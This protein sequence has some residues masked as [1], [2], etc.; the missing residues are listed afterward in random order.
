MGFL[1]NRIYKILGFVSLSIIATFVLVYFFNPG[2]LNLSHFGFLK[3]DNAITL[4]LDLSKIDKSKLSPS[5]NESQDADGSLKNLPACV[6]LPIN[7][8]SVL[9]FNKP[10]LY[11][12]SELKFQA[13]YDKL[14]LPSLQSLWTSLRTMIEMTCEKQNYPMKDHFVLPLQIWNRLDSVKSKPY[15]HYTGLKNEFYSI[16]FDLIS[17]RKPLETK[18]E[19]FKQPA[20]NIGDKIVFYGFKS[21]SKNLQ[22]EAQVNINCTGQYDSLDHWEIQ[23]F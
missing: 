23:E 15:T 17:K 20:F 4:D 16:G 21:L 13:Q 1:K 19:C 11:Q 18:E 10:F 5:Q 9:K 7:E 8:I 12:N 3:S 6:Y 2:F 22:V 14:K